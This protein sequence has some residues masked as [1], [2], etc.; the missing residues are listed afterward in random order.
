MVVPISIWNIAVWNCRYFAAC[1]ARFSRE[2]DE[3]KKDRHSLVSKSLQSASCHWRSRDYERQQKLSG[4]LLR[5]RN[6]SLATHPH[7][8]FP[9][10]CAQRRGHST[11]VNACIFAIER[12]KWRHCC[13]RQSRVVVRPLPV[14]G[15]TDL[16]ESDAQLSVFRAP[17]ENRPG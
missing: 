7:L 3:C 6:R 14:A 9:A 8:A 4:F 2:R 16:A 17:P 1:F 5:G 11:Q 12:A 13:N 10:P 15:L